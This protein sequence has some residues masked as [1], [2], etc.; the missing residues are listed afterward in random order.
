MIISFARELSP[1]RV[2]E[3]ISVHIYIWQHDYFI[4]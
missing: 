4:R 3:Y 2:G 1:T